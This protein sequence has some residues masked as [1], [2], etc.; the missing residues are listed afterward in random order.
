[1]VE[2]VVRSIGPVSAVETSSPS[3]QREDRVKAAFDRQAR[4]LVLRTLEQASGYSLNSRILLHALDDW[5][6]TF[7][8]PGLV[9]LLEW[10]GGE[11]LVALRYTDEVVV[12]TLRQKGADVVHGRERHDGVDRPLPPS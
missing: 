5:A 8:H 12:A 10:L 6:L 11:G 1:M 4:A 9:T 7:T 2:T 3:D